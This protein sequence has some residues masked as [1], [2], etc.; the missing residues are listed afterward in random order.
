MN[1]ITAMGIVRNWAIPH[2]CKLCSANF[3]SR[4]PRQF[5]CATCSES[6][7]L[8]RKKLD[9]HRVW[10]RGKR[11]RARDT[12]LEI[13]KREQRSLVDYRQEPQL[14]WWV[15]IRYPFSWAASKNA[16]YS[17]VPK[18]HIALRKDANQWRNGLAMLLKNAVRNMQIVQNK[19]WIDIYVEK[20]NHKGDAI[21]VVDSVCDAVKIAV[22][23]DDRWFCIRHLDWAINK[24]DPEIFIGVGQEDVPNAQACSYC[25]R[26]LAFDQFTINRSC[27][28]GI[29]RVCRECM[30]KGKSRS[31]L[32]AAL[33]ASVAQLE[34]E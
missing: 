4:N 3:I 15:C 33:R 19:L 13:S 20:P 26:I 24:N 30:A 8:K 29:H 5:Y 31:E 1:E 6:Q 16:I 25:G 34:G 21:N 18:G 12:G 2:Q 11:D 10:N 27:K 28:N 22:G 14:K 7:D 17:L 23:I 32:R 9:H